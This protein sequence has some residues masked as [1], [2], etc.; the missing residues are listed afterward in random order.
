MSEGWTTSGALVTVHPLPVSFVVEALDRQL[1]ANAALGEDRPASS[2]YQHRATEPFEDELT[3]DMYC[4]ADPAA[5]GSDGGLG[6]G[7]KVVELKNIHLE[8]EKVGWLGFASL[9]LAWLGLAWL[10]VTRPDVA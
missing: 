3:G 9:R 8:G 7:Y 4:D 10:G 2:W 5:G 6:A 1:M